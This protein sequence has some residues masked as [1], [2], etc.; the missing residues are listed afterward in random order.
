MK[1]ETIHLSYL[2]LCHI[3]NFLD[4]TF[5]LAAISLGVEEANPIMAYLLGISPI[6]FI[7]AKFG[8]FTVAINFLAKRNGNL[9]LP[10]LAV[11]MMVVAWHVSFWLGL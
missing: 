3:L 4:A 10:I 9:L 8:V 11:Y 5:T 2:I 7:V 1:K 6:L